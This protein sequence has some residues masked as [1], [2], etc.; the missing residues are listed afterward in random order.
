MHYSEIKYNWKIRQFLTR[1]KIYILI[2]QDPFCK[3][4][5]TLAGLKF[6]DLYIGRI[7]N[8]S[9]KQNIALLSLKSWEKVQ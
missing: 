6:L 4:Q 9:K 2:S 5:C 3:I 7:K 8:I 1:T